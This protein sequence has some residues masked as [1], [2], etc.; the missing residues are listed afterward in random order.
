MGAITGVSDTEVTY[1][2]ATGTITLTKAV[3]IS[4]VVGTY[5]II[6]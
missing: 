2:A 4:N 3:N 1:T 5:F 6:V